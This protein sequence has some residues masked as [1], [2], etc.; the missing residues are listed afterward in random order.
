M[1]IPRF[2][3][4]EKLL[5]VGRDIVAAYMLVFVLAG[6][7]TFAQD[8]TAGWVLPHLDHLPRDLDLRELLF[9]GRVL[10]RRQ[11]RLAAGDDL[12]DLVEVARADEA[13]VLDR[14]ISVAVLARE[15]LLLHARVS[16]H[17]GII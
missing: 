9:F 1:R 16:G 3:C 15:F 10:Q 2:P 12:R 14:G 4:Q 17:A 6:Q 8:R 13:L 11:R 5:I 7:R